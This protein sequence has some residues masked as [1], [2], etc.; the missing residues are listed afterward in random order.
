MV[1]T[2]NDRL[3][4]ALVPLFLRSNQSFIPGEELK[5]DLGKLD[6]RY[7]A[8]PQETKTRGVYAFASF[9]P[10]DN[11]F[12]T[13]RLWDKHMSPNWKDREVPGPRLNNPAV[14][15]L[16][17]K[18]KELEKKAKTEGTIQPSWLGEPDQ[19][20]IRRIVSGKRGKWTRFPPEVMDRRKNADGDWED[21][22]SK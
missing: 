13:T 14:K 7:D 9:P 4:K 8:L 19:I 3:H 20:V 6:A 10:H 5:K 15:E 22:P 2:S 11:S 1:F 12:L 21:I 16:M 18:I 17:E